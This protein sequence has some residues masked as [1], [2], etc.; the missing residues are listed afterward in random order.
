MV[1]DDGATY[2]D[3]NN[4]FTTLYLGH[5]H[6]DTT[7]AAKSAVADGSCFGLPT[8]HEE[9]HAEAIVSR[10]A[11]AE[12]VRYTSTG[13]EAV[14]TATRLARAVTGRKRLVFLQGAYH[15]WSDS[16]LVAASTTNLDG[17][18]D[19]VRDDCVLL[20]INDF[21]ALERIFADY[22]DSIAALTIDLLPNRLGLVAVDAEWAST[23]RRLCSRY[24]AM[25]IVDE[26]I[27]FRLAHGGLQS[28][29]GL[30]PDLT[31]LGKTIGGGFAIGAVAGTRDAMAPLDPS[32]QG[33]IEHGG[34]FAANPVALRTGTTAL[35]LMT[36]AEIA[37]LNG[38]G[39]LLRDRLS[40]ELAGHGWDVRSR[41]SLFRL[42][43]TDAVSAV[44][45]ARVRKLWHEALR[46][47]LLLQPTGAGC[48]STP[49]DSGTV[50]EVVDLLVESATASTEG[51]S[52]DHAVAIAAEPTTRRRG[53]ERC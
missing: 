35:R 46:R 47:N 33:A 30:R 36:A 50:D 22:G 27:S 25:L 23:A 34:T 24:G 3:L 37:R 2:I 19:G 15:G 18:P 28:I 1:T 29:Y 52:P 7:E 51:W 43:P 11:G 21:D 45:K 38:L 5:A 42:V 26:V 13:T 44:G 16:A 20:P 17:I 41:G 12:V 49:M 32:G 6:P 53:N 48:L 40:S 8:I 31:V 39:D 14:M 4:N 9:V 10:L